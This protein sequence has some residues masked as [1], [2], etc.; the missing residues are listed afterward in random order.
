MVF[1]EIIVFL[2]L[3]YLIILFYF[4]YFEKYIFSIILLLFFEKVSFINWLLNMR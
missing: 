3:V 1:L 4:V 2:V